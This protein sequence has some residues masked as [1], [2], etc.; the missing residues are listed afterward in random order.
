MIALPQLLLVA[1]VASRDPPWLYGKEG[2]VDLIQLIDS[3]AYDARKAFDHLGEMLVV[4]YSLKVIDM[5]WICEQ[6]EKTRISSG[7]NPEKIIRAFAGALEAKAGKE[8]I[9]SALHGQSVKKMLGDRWSIVTESL[10]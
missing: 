4:M 9:A 10:V 7:E 5:G 3:Y 1:E 6:S 8:S 2:L